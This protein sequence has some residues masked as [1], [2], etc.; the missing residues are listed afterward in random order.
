MKIRYNRVST[1]TQN[2]GRQQVNGNNYDLTID[3]VSSG[4]I[5]FFDR[6]GGKQFLNI[7]KKDNVKELHIQSIDR[8]GRNIIDILQVVQYLNENDIN[9]F[10]QNLGLYSLVNSKPNQSFKLIISVLGNIAEMERENLL[11]R[12]KVGIEL[13]KT[14]GVY[15]GR[16]KGS[17]ISDTNFIKKYQIAYNELKKGETI[18]RASL[19]GKCSIGTAFKLKK[20]I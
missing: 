3:D 20:L 6:S 11:E 10:V 9:L 5:P 1:S 19:L 4:S 18:E 7:L 13:A 8:L 14:R 16:K 17:T 12:Q 2:L 15:K